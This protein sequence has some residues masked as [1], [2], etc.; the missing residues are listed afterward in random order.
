MGDTIYVLYQGD[1]VIDIGTKEE[2]AKRRNV[3]PETI[4]HYSTPAYKKRIKGQD[5]RLVA[6]K[7]DQ[8]G[9]TK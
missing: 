2:L 8:C 9:G 5:K 7:V 3:S 6:V 4:C 1:E